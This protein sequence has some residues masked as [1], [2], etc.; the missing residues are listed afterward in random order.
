MHFWGIFSNDFLADF[1][2]DGFSWQ[3]IYCFGVSAITCR[4]LF[5]KNIAGLTTFSASLL[6]LE[7]N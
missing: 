2:E 6:E 3:G 5:S 7:M 4:Y 1:V